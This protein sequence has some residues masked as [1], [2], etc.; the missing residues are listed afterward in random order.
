MSPT[1]VTGASTS[2]TVGSSARKSFT[3]SH[4]S[5]ISPSAKASHLSVCVNHFMVR[6]IS[7]SSSKES[8]SSFVGILTDMT[9]TKSFQINHLHLRTNLF[10]LPYSALIPLLRHHKVFFE[11]L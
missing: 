11:H 2:I 10:V 5:S 3:L 8:I 7:S 6:L 1:T 9:S 4:K